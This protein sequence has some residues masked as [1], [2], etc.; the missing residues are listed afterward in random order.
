[1]IENHLIG[2]KNYYQVIGSKVFL[3]TKHS[4]RRL[5]VIAGGI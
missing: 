1:M 3:N 4:I 5:S 2:L